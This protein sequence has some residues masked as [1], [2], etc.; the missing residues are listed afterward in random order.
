MQGQ[1]QSRGVGSGCEEDRPVPAFAPGRD[2]F[3]Q[4]PTQSLL[5]YDYNECY[6]NT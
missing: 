2:T 3:V 1:A 4:Q 6:K 5:E